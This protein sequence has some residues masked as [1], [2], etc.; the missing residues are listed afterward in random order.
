M[1][2]VLDLKD[3]FWHVKLDEESS[4]VCTFTSPFGRYCFTRLP[5]GISSALEVF[6][7][8]TSEGFG[9]INGVLCYFDDL[10]ISGGTEVEHDRALI[11]VLNRARVLNIKFNKEKFKFKQNTVSY[12]GHEISHEGVRP[13]TKHIE[14]V[15]KLK[16]PENKKE[17]LR[18]L[19]L[20]KYVVKF[21]LNLSKVI[22]P[23]RQRTQNNIEF[24]LQGQHL[25]SVDKLKKLLSTSPIL[26]TFNNKNPIIIQTD[27]SRDGLGS[28]LIQHGHVVSYVSRSLNKRNNM[29]K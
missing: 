13:D 26:K 14:A 15:I 27:A 4:K 10:I 1:F 19:G 21:I 16:Y 22:A 17:L 2:S 7:R 23:L 9:D 25:Q 24:Q 8:K 18:L 5:F 12:V 3:G 20:V 6:Q 28:A 29:L 11:S